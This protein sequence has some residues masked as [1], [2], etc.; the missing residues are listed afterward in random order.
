[1]FPIIY[2]HPIY[3]TTIFC[4]A[5]TWHQCPPSINHHNEPDLVATYSHPDNTQTES[6]H[7]HW[8]KTPATNIQNH[9]PHPQNTTTEKPASALNQQ[10]WRQIPNQERTF[11]QHGGRE[12]AS[13]VDQNPTDIPRI[14]NK[15]KTP[16]QI[17]YSNRKKG[18]SKHPQHSLMWQRTLTT[19]IY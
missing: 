17:R 6:S 15:T 2:H 5:N 16:I 18:R 19:N 7:P 12:P 3:L 13:K 8:I 14:S 11:A 4:R 10:K 1:M 9:Q